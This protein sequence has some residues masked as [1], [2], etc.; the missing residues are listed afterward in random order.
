MNHS[1]IAE[2]Y[3]CLGGGMG[4]KFSPF[5]TLWVLPILEFKTQRFIRMDAK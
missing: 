1:C 3:F 5:S 2:R 4:A